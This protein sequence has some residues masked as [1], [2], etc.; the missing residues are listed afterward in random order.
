M[1]KCVVWVDIVPL[2]DGWSVESSKRIIHLGPSSLYTCAYKHRR[3][4]ADECVLDQE[5]QY[6][7]V[8]ERCIFEG[9]GVIRD[10]GFHLI[11]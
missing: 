10:L 9:T 4:W 8:G 3:S 11:I 2:L 7:S 6:A 5:H 1:Q